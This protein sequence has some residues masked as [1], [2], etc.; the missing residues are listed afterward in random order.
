MSSVAAVVAAATEFITL[1]PA[2]EADID[3]A[4]APRERVTVRRHD[5][6]RHV[7]DRVRHHLDRRG[8]EEQTTVQIVGVRHSEVGELGREQARLRPEVLLGGAMQ[9]EVVGA[10]VGEDRGGEPRPVDAVQR[11]G[12]RGDLHHDGHV[13]VVMERAPGG[14]AARVPRASCAVPTASRSTRSVALRRGGWRRGGA[15]SSSCR[16]CR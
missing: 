14:P 12:V 15:P 2:A 8:V 9:V 5:D 6:V 4:A 1:N 7:A 11:Q 3:A 16:S 13:A 10:E